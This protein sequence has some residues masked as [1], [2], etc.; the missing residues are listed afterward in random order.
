MRRLS[1]NGSGPTFSVHASRRVGSLKARKGSS[2]HGSTGRGPPT[3]LC[4]CENGD[5]Q[6]EGRAAELGQVFFIRSIKRLA[7]SLA[8]ISA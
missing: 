8:F 4:C 3:L 6:Q 1:T 7:A 5:G 2:T